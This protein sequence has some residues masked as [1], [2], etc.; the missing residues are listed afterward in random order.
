MSNRKVNRIKDHYKQ[1]D[2]KLGPARERDAVCDGPAEAV[3]LLR[4]KLNV[5]H[6]T[7]SLLRSHTL[8]KVIISGLLSTPAL[9]RML[10]LF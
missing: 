7:R 1:D 2:H 10:T 3:C 9:L 6:Q 8:S 4:A 5:R